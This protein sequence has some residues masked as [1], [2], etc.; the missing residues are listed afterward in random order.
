MWCA[1]SKV[2]MFA[3]A[4]FALGYYQINIGALKQTKPLLRFLTK[5]SL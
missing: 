1:A 3:R 5:K 4:D 2:G